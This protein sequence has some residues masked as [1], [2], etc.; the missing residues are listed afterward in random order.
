LISMFDT[1]FPNMP[2]SLLVAFGIC[3][4]AWFAFAVKE[5]VSPPKGYRYGPNPVW[6]FFCVLS[7]LFGA[8]SLW[9][10]LQ[11]EGRVADSFANKPATAKILLLEGEIK[12]RAKNVSGVEKRRLSR[13]DI[14]TGVAHV[15]S[16][17]DEELVRNLRESREAHAEIHGVLDGGVGNHP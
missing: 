14:T 4:L 13:G 9:T 8:M 7:G 2:V 6:F 5:V 12:Y 10:N 15:A 16:M 17:T 3:F 1:P 11:L